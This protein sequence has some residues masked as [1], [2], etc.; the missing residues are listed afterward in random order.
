MLTYE[1]ISVIMY[2]TISV[3][4]YILTNK[5]YRGV[6]NMTNIKTK[7]LE[8]NGKRAFNWAGGRSFCYDEETNILY[9]I[10]SYEDREVLDSKPLIEDNW[11]RHGYYHSMRYNEELN[12]RDF[13]Y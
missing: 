4:M 9:W 7:G 10:L 2:E 11:A 12:K 6:I 5:N 3:I 1:T 8:N 13:D